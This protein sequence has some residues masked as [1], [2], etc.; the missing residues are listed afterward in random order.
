MDGQD[1]VII[2]NSITYD[3]RNVSENEAARLRHMKLHEEHKGHEAMHLEMFLI[4]VFFTCGC[5][6]LLMFWKKYRPKSYHLFTLLAMW[7]VPICYSVYMLYFRFIAIWFLFS[8]ISG[9]MIYLSSNP[10]ISTTTPRRVYW[11]FLL[12]HKIS[13]SA[14]LFGYLLVLLCMFIPQIISPVFAFPVGGLILFYGVYFGLIARDFAEVCTDK[15]AAHIS[16]FSESGIPLRKID[17][18][19]CALC[20]N[21]MLNGQGEKM[22][23][24]NCTHV[25]HEFCLRGWCIVGKKDTCP[26]CKE[27]VNLHKLI[28]NPWEKPHLL[29]GNLLDGIR[30]LVAWQPLI[31]MAVHVIIWA[32]DL[33]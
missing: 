1:N 24:L 22:Y 25:F 27:K 19:V 5:Q 15:M 11:W 31:L 10:R 20:T 14:T 8:L 26:Y 2:V 21:V 23:K 29:F 3:L 7:I 16:Y 17:P 12:M 4:L 13:Y 6:F 33:K 9:V 28:K 30:Y 32:L 18:G